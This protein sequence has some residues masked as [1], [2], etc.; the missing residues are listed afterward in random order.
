MGILVRNGLNTSLILL[1]MESHHL[2][3]IIISK[4]LK[5]NRIRIAIFIREAAFQRCSTEKPF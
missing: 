1:F 5:Q 4:E 2:H 3:K